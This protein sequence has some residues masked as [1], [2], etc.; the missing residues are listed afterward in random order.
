MM[1][2]DWLQSARGVDAGAVDR[3]LGARYV[4]ELAA[5]VRRPSRAAAVLMLFS[6]HSLD[7]AAVLLTHR[8]PSMRS[9][10]GQIAFPGGH[11]EEGETPVEAALRE[12]REETGLDASTAT[13]VEE[14]NPLTIRV[15]GNPVSPVLAYWH[16][17][18]ELF[19]ASPE[20]T[21]DV[22]TAPVRELLDPVNRLSIR[23]GDWQGHAF[24]YNGY[25]I[26]GFTGGVLSGLFQHAG[27]EQDWDRDTVHDLRQVLA[28]SRNNEK[29]L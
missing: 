16:S 22:F 29:K 19:A 23:L 28:S 14:W 20:E 26:W 11:L 10:S 8:S 5:K 13:V 21:D 4:K 2:P 6:G 1:I 9:H 27:W 7:D 25:V 18:S 24:R 15:S 3:S 17:P 12:A